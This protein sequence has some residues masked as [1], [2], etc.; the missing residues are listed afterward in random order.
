MD[1]E[2]KLHSMMVSDYGDE[3]LSKD[4]ELN[5]SMSISATQNGDEYQRTIEKENGT[6]G[7]N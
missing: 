6:G 4:R 1:N 3:K 2:T 7:N 5:A